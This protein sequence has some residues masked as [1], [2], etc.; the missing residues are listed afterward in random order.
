M[1]LAL[2]P[3]AR[4]LLRRVSGTNAYTALELVLLILLALQCARLV[5]TAVAPVGPIGDWRSESMMRPAAS[6]AGL[7]GGFDP[8]FRLNGQSGPA[9]VT[10]LDLALYGIRQ[11][12]ATGRGSA[13]IA[14]PDGR[15]RSYAVGEEIVPGVTL[16]AVDFDSV[17]IGRGGVAE[18]LYMDQS[19]APN[20]VGPAAP[21]QPLAAPAAPLA[22]PP[23]AVPRGFAAD[24]GFQPRG[25]GGRISGVVVVPQGSGDGFRA[26]GFAPGDVIIAVDGRRIDSAARAQAIAADLAGAR[27][28][29]VQVERDGRVVTLRVRGGQ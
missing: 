22:V 18:Q 28:A 23:P 3:R 8:F 10:S 4:R 6:P 21:A 19:P 1:R 16:D 27:V 15:Q 7:L 26:A 14:T 17:T 9:V 12:Q 25:S 13:I 2:D 20:V 29:D 5:W 11:D 24:I